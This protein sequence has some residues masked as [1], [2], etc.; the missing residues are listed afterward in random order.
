[1][2]WRAVLPAVAVT[3]ACLVWGSAWPRCRWFG[4]VVWRGDI[5]REPRRLALLF[6]GLAEGESAIDLLALLRETNTPAA[7][8]VDQS[9]ATRRPELLRRMD[10]EGHLIVNAGSGFT[11]ANLF[12]GQ[13]VWRHMIDATDDAI[14]AAIGRRPLLFAPPLSMKSPMMLREAGWCGYGLVVRSRGQHAWLPKRWDTF[15]MK[16]VP[17]SG[18]VALRADQARSAEQLAWLLHAWRD[19]GRIATRLDLLL[20]VQPYRR[21]TVMGR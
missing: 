5:E 20:H 2:W 19:R 1:M 18:V 12:L 8:A 10:A 9:T 21:T 7:F 16:R 6:E 4:P 13:S 11:L 14:H 17:A 3:T 15:R